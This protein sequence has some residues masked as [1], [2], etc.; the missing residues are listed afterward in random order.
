MQN[1]YDFDTLL[2]EVE[3]IDSFRRPLSSSTNRVGIVQLTSQCIIT[4]CAKLLYDFGGFK[5]AYEAK[6]QPS[7]FAFYKSKC[8]LMFYQKNRENIYTRHKKQLGYKNYASRIFI[9][10]RLADFDK[11]NL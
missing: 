6:L 8:L 5:N 1:K 7:L 10:T 3:A 2:V 4:M 11:I 9:G